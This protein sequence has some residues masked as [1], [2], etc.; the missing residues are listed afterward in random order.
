MSGIVLRRCPFANC[1][2]LARPLVVQR[3]TRRVKCPPGIGYDT[4]NPDSTCALRHAADLLR[5]P[6][7]L[8]LIQLPAVHCVYERLCNVVQPRCAGNQQQM[9]TRLE[10][11]HCGVGNALVAQDRH[12]I[13]IVRDDQPIEFQGIAQHAD[14]SFPRYWPTAASSAGNI[15]GPGM[16]A[17]TPAAI[18][19]RNT[20]RP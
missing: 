20:A 8:L 15:A 4:Y 17:L 9:R 14:D 6:Q 12:R 11:C 13:Q 18:T 10:R 1:A 5:R 3:V 16:M 7:Q 19:S 2:R